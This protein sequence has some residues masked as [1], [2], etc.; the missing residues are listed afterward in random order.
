MLVPPLPATASSA[1]MQQANMDLRTRLETTSTELVTGRRDDLTAHL[2]GRIGD[3]ML[4]GKVLEDLT[5]QRE[6]FSLKGNR[7]T[8]VQLA[9]QMAQDSTQGVEVATLDALARDDGPALELATRD[10]RDAL[11]QVFEALET[12]HGD[13]FLFSGD[14]TGTPPLGRVED[15]L[16]DIRDL[17]L[18][19]P[20]AG[21]FEAA[22][23][24]YFEDPAGG[25]ATGIYQ[26]SP[27]ASDPDA[28]LA[29]DPA[30]TEM[31]RG[32]SVIAVSAPSS[33]P[34]LFAADTTVI[35]TAAESL[36]GGR[37]ALVSRRADIGRL[38]ENIESRLS[39][40]DV[41]ETIA[42]ELFNAMTARD[43]YEAATELRELETNL[44]ASYLLSSR[45][46]ELTFVNY[47]R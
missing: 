24:T 2:S 6:Q 34:P 33:A 40:L 9:L 7:L 10:A 22:L 16:D 15:L 27:N 45:L 12:R 36:S 39:R 17:A 18:G 35:S 43:P 23:D 13:R 1:R 30:I 4:S 31:A 37:D 20:T 25:W 28:I 42:T 29:I 41:E 26:G 14:Q 46:A 21:A 5:T 47:V 38:Q 8:L 19:A 32:L 3:A 44:Q 11:E